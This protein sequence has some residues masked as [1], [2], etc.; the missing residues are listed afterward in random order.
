MLTA[1]ET[2]D[3]ALETAEIVLER[4]LSADCKPFVEVPME[5]VETLVKTK[6]DNTET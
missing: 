2:T 5:R 1:F 4:A 6:V 3:T